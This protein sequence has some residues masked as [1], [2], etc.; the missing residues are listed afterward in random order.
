M[1]LEKLARD[2]AYWADRVRTLKKL[3]EQSA[4]GCDRRQMK[5]GLSDQENW[6]RANG[7]TCIHVAY[8]EWRNSD[9]NELGQYETGF[10]EFWEEAILEG[11]AC[12]ACQNVRRYKA[13]RMQARNR[14]GAVRAAITRV[15]RR[16]AAP[17]C[18]TCG[19]T[20]E[21]DETL[22][23]EPTSDQHAPCPDCTKE[24]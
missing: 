11:R 6:A 9:L 14:L 5:S 10:E 21:I 15:G 17:D 24:S 22:G 16:L 8:G 4:S 7:D 18:G 19:G 13:E 20:G 3:G 2:H 12:L 23:G 1:S